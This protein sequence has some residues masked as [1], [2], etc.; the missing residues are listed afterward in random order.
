VAVAGPGFWIGKL[1]SRKRFLQMVRNI[2]QRRAR[3]P[4]EG[5]AVL[6]LAA[7]ATGKYVTGTSMTRQRACSAAHIISG[8]ERGPGLAQ[9]RPDALERLLRPQRPEGCSRRR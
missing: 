4:Q 1:R 9:Q 6:A 7:H 5:V 8:E 3:L 2:F